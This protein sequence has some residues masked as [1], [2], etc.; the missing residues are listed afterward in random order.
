[1]PDHSPAPLP[2]E[3]VVFGAGGFGL[4]VARACVAAGIQVHAIIDRDDQRGTAEFTYLRLDDAVLE[5]VVVLLGV[6]NPGA[7]VQAIA[8]ELLSKGCSA[9]LAP[10]AFIAQ[11]SR[12]SHRL[13]N[14]W[15]TDST[16]DFGSSAVLAARTLLADEES[17]ACF[18]RTL[19][20]RSE[21][22]ILEARP[23]HAMSEQY[24]PNDFEFLTRGMRYVDVG[25]FDGDTVRALHAHAPTDVNAIFAFEPDPLNYGRVV[26]E[27]ANWPG[28]E[29][30]AAP[31]AADDAARTLRFSSTPGGSASLNT[32]GDVTVQTV[33]LDDLLLHWNPTHIKMDIEGAEPAALLGLEETLRRYR[34]RLAISAYHL[35]EH[36]WS[37][38][39]WLAGLDLGYRFHMRAYAQ[40]TFDTVVYAVPL[41]DHRAG[42]RRA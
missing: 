37:L 18:D 39:N 41:D 24:L 14:Y 16:V 23:E 36:H 12:G 30:Q 10:P 32:S 21:G 3:V 17:R 9:V 38:L 6:H 22:A 34:P 1:M 7:D 27:L 26:Q 42:G 25:A 4:R 28:L 8:D 35:P 15:L 40:Q 13:E 11:L 2:S 5:N 29:W 31:L 20:Y 19:R 33:A